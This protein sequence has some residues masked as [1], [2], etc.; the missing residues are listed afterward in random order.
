MGAI[1]DHMGPYWAHT[2]PY[3]A[4]LV[5]SL[6]SYFYYFFRPLAPFVNYIFPFSLPFQ[7]YTVL[8]SS[9]SFSCF[10]FPIHFFFF[11]F[12]SALFFFLCFH[13]RRS[14][15]LRYSVLI[16]PHPCYFSCLGVFRQ[17]HRYELAVCFEWH[18]L[19]FL[20]RFCLGACHSRRG[21]VPCLCYILPSVFLS[22]RLCRRLISFHHHLT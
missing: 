11:F 20:I 22:N 3:G 10:F 13:L 8:L 12:F 18:R 19:S 5:L 14:G 16:L 15:L 4:I 9:F 6:F 7:K 17:H 21:N 1:R 2:G